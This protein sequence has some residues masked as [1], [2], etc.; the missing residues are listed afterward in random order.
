MW[1]LTNN[2]DSHSIEWAVC[3]DLFRNIRFWDCAVRTGNYFK[4][5]LKRIRKQVICRWSCLATASTLY[6]NFY[7]YEMLTERKL[8]GLNKT[9]I[10]S[11]RIGSDRIDKTRTG[12]DPI[13]K[14]WIGLRPIDKTRTGSEKSR[15]VISSP[16]PPPK[17]IVKWYLNRR[18]RRKK[19]DVALILQEW[20][21]ALVIMKMMKENMLYWMMIPF[22]SEFPSMLQ[23]VSSQQTFRAEISR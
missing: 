2:I 11:D 6:L 7:E 18:W 21:R 19:C 22:A 1:F 20:L 14:S 17:K 13:D 12:S 15:I 16:L 4:N 9:R 3:N 23:N 10:E 5:I 8:W